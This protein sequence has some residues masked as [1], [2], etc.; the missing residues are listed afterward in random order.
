MKA[1]R[2]HQF[3]GP[4]V[5]K[6][7]ELPDPEPGPGEVVVRVR[8]I[9]V[10]PV[11]TYIRSGKYPVLP[12]LPYTPGADAAGVIESIGPE[13]RSVKPGDRVF[14]GGTVAGNGFG[15]YATHALSRQSQVYPLPENVTFDEGA[16]VN[17][18]YCTAYRALFHR[19]RIKPG[20]TILIHGATGG[21]GIAA[22][23]FAVAIGAV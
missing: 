18:A 3:G 7:E 4:E 5:L 10:N 12:Q 14:I 15:A 22:V 17:V 6:L 13:V 1:I 11:D 20:E 2:V 9:G 8:A 23:Q 16:A 21:V 19:A